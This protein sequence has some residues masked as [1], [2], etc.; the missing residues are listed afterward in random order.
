MMHLSTARSHVIIDAQF[1]GDPKRVTLFGESAGAGSI[2]NHLVMEASRG[3]FHSAILESAAFAAW[4]SHPMQVAETAYTQ[5]LEATKCQTVECLLERSASNLTAAVN[6][7]PIG[8]CCKFW[9]APRPYIQWAPTV[10]GVELSAHPVELMRQGKWANVPLMHGANRDEG[11]VFW[12]MERDKNKSIPD[13]NVK[14]EELESFLTRMYDP[15]M[16]PGSGK[17]LVKLYLTNETHP[18][19]LR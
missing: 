17:E 10:D 7:I 18:S 19:V 9:E 3:L 1:G 12:L 2:T 15:L 16:G 6:T 8:T 4:A 14:P 11:A 5:V 13:R